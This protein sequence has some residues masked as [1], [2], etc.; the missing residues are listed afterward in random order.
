MQ[1]VHAE[2]DFPTGDLLITDTISIP[3]FIDVVRLDHATESMTDFGRAE[4][5]QKIAAQGI[6]HVFHPY[7]PK[8]LTMEN[9]GLNFVQFD[10]PEDEREHL[11]DRPDSDLWAVSVID[12]ETLAELI[13]DNRGCTRG[14]ALG[15]IATAL[16]DRPGIIERKVEPGTYHLYFGMNDDV[17]LDEYDISGIDQD[18]LREIMVLSPE[19][20]DLTPKPGSKIA[21]ALE[22]MMSAGGPR[23]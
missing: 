5:S 12:K 13:E 1:A 9:G 18:G 3:E 19:P 15:V 7:G 17:N 23:L 11:L 2:V 21:A 14:E 22:D 10:D 16:E 20:L 8:I 4:R 6:A